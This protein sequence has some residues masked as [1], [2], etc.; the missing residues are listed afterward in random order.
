MTELSVFDL[1]CVTGASRPETCSLP[2]PEWVGE[3]HKEVQG[4]R[5]I[6]AVP[7]SKRFIREHNALSSDCVHGIWDDSHDRRLEALDKLRR[8]I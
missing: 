4:N 6:D 8:G 7:L 1:T 2:I 5:V 3:P